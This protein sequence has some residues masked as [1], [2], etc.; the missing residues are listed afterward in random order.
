MPAFLPA[1]AQE[2]RFPHVATE[3]DLG[4]YGVGTFR[5]DER[6]R[7]G[8]STFLFGDIEGALHFTP[9]LALQVALAFEPVGEGDSTG[10]TPGGVTVLRR[11]GA[12]FESFRLEWKP[13]EEVTLYAGRFVAPFGRG[14][15]D[16]PGI[17]PKIR[18]HEAYI[19][20]D[21]L[22]FGGTARVVSDLT[23]GEHDLSAALF[24]LDRTPLS[25]TFF[26]RR[27]CCDK[28]FDRFTRNT[29]ALGGPGNS[30]RLDSFAVALDGDRIAAL[31]NFS[32]HLAVLSR[33][34]G[35][36]GTAREWGYAAGIRHETRWSD[37]QSTLLFAEGVQFR[38]AGARPLVEVTSFNPD[39]VE[40][41]ARRERRSFTTL[42]VQHRVGE[43]R[44]TLAW[45]RAERK[46][47]VGTLPMEN[48]VE[49]SPGRAPIPTLGLDVGSQDGRYARGEDL[50]LGTSHAVLVRLGYT[51][52]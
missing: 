37:T 11:Q 48:Y 20:R 28:R 39:L 12:F 24:T 16:F 23:L 6:G 42:G 29:A 14:Y 7:R 10:T 4:F 52:L 36:D 32:Y 25:T 43:W 27:R 40:T 5:V 1:A 41:V 8:L 21:S 34:P 47:S 26:T 46:R 22:G 49:L 51:G 3:S 17:L 30:G 44:T 31:P 50:S 38:N 15:E 9:T 13:R 45:Q 18:A 33:A 2:V 35:R 19:I